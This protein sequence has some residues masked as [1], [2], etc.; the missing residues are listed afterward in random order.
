MRQYPRYLTCSV[1][2][3]MPFHFQRDKVPRTWF[4]EWRERISVTSELYFLCIEM[5]IICMILLSFFD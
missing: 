4:R 1:F 3:R 2:V 5:R